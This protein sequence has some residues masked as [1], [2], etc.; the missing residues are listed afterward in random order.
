MIRVD[1]PGGTDLRLAQLVL[2]V[3]GTLTE[4]GQLLEGV[5]E[6]VRRPRDVAALHL[7]SADTFGTAEV[8]ARRI[9]AD[10]SHCEM[11]FSRRRAVIATTRARC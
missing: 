6:R 2:D 4:R 3:S 11:A 5:E 7:L 10:L 9:G 8:V 1:V